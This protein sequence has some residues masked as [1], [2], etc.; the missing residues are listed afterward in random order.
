[1]QADVPA[2]L[3]EDLHVNVRTLHE[4][5]A[6]VQ[7]EERLGTGV[8]VDNEDQPPFVFAN[9][10][11]G[12]GS[13]PPNSTHLP[14]ISSEAPRIGPQRCARLRGDGQ[15]KTVQEHPQVLGLRATHVPKSW[16]VCHFS[17]LLTAL[18]C[19]RL[20]DG[21]MAGLPQVEDNQTCRAF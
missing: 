21:T 5:R 18:P 12:L 3:V 10:S 1:M 14:E 11:V 7:V 15:A 4:A 9:L 20:A 2:A 17:K 16:T 6:L 19:S 13:S 8:G